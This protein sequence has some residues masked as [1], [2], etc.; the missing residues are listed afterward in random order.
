MTDAYQ[1]D[2][3]CGKRLGKALL[4]GKLEGTESWVCPKCGCEWRSKI[5]EGLRYWSP[6][7]VIEIFK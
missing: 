1:E 7:E 5:I 4:S 6:H 2:P 3:C